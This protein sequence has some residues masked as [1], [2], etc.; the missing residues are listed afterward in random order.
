[1]LQE[2][3]Q[4]T[5]PVIAWCP[6][7]FLIFHPFLVM[8]AGLSSSFGGTEGG[9]FFATE[10]GVFDSLFVVEQGGVGVGKVVQF[11]SRNLTADEPFDGFDGFEFLGSDQGKG[12]AFRLGAASSPDAVHI[13]FGVL[14]NVVVD[15]MRD[16][17]DIKTTGG[18]IGLSG[19]LSGPGGLTKT[20][21]GTL[22]LVAFNTCTGNVTI[23]AGTLATAASNSN[24]GALGHAQ[25]I[26]IIINIC[27]IEIAIT[28]S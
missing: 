16:A 23:S 1:M 4:E 7:R 24:Y 5:T 25:S 26:I 21:S 19:V 10:Q 13:I 12:I 11:D 8:D 20:G 9:F 28:E 15:D 3:G 22:T 6:R 2:L 14:R 18:D 17:A 27:L